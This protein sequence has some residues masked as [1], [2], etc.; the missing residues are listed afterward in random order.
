MWCCLVRPAPAS[1]FLKIMKTGESSLKRRRIY[2]QANLM[3]DFINIQKNHFQNLGQR[4]SGD[5]VIWATV[6]L[7]ALVSLLVVYSSTGLLAYRL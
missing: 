4:T 2:R 6:V 7:L 1:I 5:K 3:N